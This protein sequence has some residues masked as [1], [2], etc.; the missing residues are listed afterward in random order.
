MTK[1]DSYLDYFTLKDN[2]Y[3]LG[4]YEKGISI[5]HQQQ[6]AISIFYQLIK[7]GKIPKDPKFKIGI[8]GAGVAGI[9]FA[10][11]AL[12]YGVSVVIIE[13][14]PEILHMQKECC[15]RRL[16]PNILEWPDRGSLYPTAR[17]PLLPWSEGVAATVATEIETKFNIIANSAKIKKGVVCKIHTNSEIKSIA[18]SDSGS[19]SVSYIQHDFKKQYLDCNILIYAIGFGVEVG[20]KAKSYWRND[21]FDQTEISRSHDKRYLVS[22][23]GDGGVMEC[24]RLA[25]SN[26]SYRYFFSVLKSV[27]EKQ[28]EEIILKLRQLKHES[29]SQ[30][31][32]YLHRG[33]SGISDDFDFVITKIKQ[34][35]RI[36]G[37]KIVLNGQ[38]TFFE[39]I[40][41]KNMS[42]L[43]AFIIFLLETRSLVTY[44][45]G[46]LV[47]RDE[48]FH[49]NGRVISEDHEVVLRHGTK[50]DELINE[51]IN[52]GEDKDGFERIKELQTNSEPKNDFDYS[53]FINHITSTDVHRKAIGMKRKVFLDHRVSH[54]FNEQARDIASELSKICYHEEEE[55]DYFKLTIHRYK[56]INSKPHFQQVAS[57]FEHRNR[58]ITKDS[59]CLSQVFDIKR[60]NVGFSFMTRLPTL[61]KRLESDQF[62]KIATLLN[63]ESYFD[64]IQFANSYLS[65]PLVAKHNKDSF[66][67]LV[68]FIEAQDQQ[69]FTD[70]KIR[71]LCNCASKIMRN[72]MDLRPELFDV[73]KHEDYDPTFIP[74]VTDVQ[75]YLTNSC[76]GDTSFMNNWLINRRL[77]HFHAFET[78]TNGS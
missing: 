9:T 31:P 56:L 25:I 33:F 55:E 41:L 4:I 36:R 26:F 2:R 44:E 30:P 73:I 19:I 34:D 65:L 17:L 27:G 77:K 43:N 10:A 63:L 42:F 5:N 60:G 66:T 37:N 52:V 20:A 49:L 14:Y 28:Y 12:Q 59:T 74:K 57:Y 18:D 61:I 71:T 48:E 32:G 47:E 3:I 53:D 16:H 72:I 70:E 78:I 13:K 22:G 75:N 8:V 39:V 29:K 67:N 24:F 64:T 58:E 51:I 50:R 21:S 38:K 40:S 46:E 62:K 11:C 23:T 1:A 35:N 68:L 54:F 6:R 45:Q 69:F 15:T 7:K 76:W